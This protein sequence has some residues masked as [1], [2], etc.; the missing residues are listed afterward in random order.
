VAGEM[1]TGRFEGRVA[2]VT[3]ASR[4]LGQAISVAFSGEGAKV[5]ICARS[6]QGLEQTAA[7]ANRMQGEVLLL[8]GDIANAETWEKLVAT[9][10]S[11]WG[12]IDYL[13][14][15]AGLMGGASYI[16]DL[17]GAEFN[18]VMA[19]NVRGTWLGMKHCI[20]AM[21]QTGGG[22]IVNV[23][24]ILGLHGNP[25]QSAYC[26]SKHA[27]IGLTKTAA[28]EYAKR[29]IRVN[30]VC[31]AAHETEMFKDY[32]SRFNDDE[33]AL[34]VEGKYPLGRVGKVQEVSSVVLF[35]CSPAASNLHGVAIPI[36]GGYAAQ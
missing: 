10:L 27:V 17:D 14:N 32:R 23:S 3:G 7:M 36:D 19:T 29:G 12:R 20:P 4:G 21:L 5:V 34:R 1:T 16:C 35:L 8:E 33:W 11:K 13:V 31:P 30:A 26:A 24:S 25:G 6:L 18:A 22:A 15:N 2:V 28:L 9:T